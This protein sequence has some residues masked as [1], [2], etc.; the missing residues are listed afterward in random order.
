V[1]RPELPSFD[2]VVATIGRERE[3][4]RLLRSIERQRYERVRVIV[5]DQNED[6]RVGRA[7]AGSDLE[8][9][10]L[11]AEPGLSR[12]RN[13]GLAAIEADVVGF[14]DDDCELPPGLLERVAQRLGALDGISGRTADAGRSAGRWAAEPGFVDRNGVWHRVNSAAL[15]LR[16]GVVREVGDFD[17]RLGL[18]GSSGEEVDYV[19]RA[20][21]TGA[22]ILYDPT[23]VVRH[24]QPEQLPGIGR[25][26]GA[27]IGYLL[28]KH[29]FPARTVA[30]M[31]A[32]PIGGVALSIARR[33]LTRA[34]FHAA[35][36]AGRVAGYRGA[37][38][39]NSSS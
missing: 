22:R 31:L 21:A 17:E 20:L 5:V 19:L 26:D 18:P 15:F 34:R 24:E 3:L 16:A 35:T 38:R 27:S 29:R 10:V 25:R 23:L 8:L 12:A 9:L 14:P 39:S 13:V 28:R 33:D 6:D 32:R 30:R 11:Q 36:L 7:L 37:S 4:A 1:G 2:L